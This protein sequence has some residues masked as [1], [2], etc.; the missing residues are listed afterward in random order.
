MATEGSLIKLQWKMVTCDMHQNNSIETA[1]LSTHNILKVVGWGGGG[2]TL[3]YMQHV[4]FSLVCQGVMF[5][6][7]TCTLSIMGR[8]PYH[9]GNLQTFFPKRKKN[10]KLQNLI[11]QVQLGKENKIEQSCYKGVSS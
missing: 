9:R 5:P 10:H 6:P 4:L 1:Q 3:L 7:Y 11:Y 8:G 2:L